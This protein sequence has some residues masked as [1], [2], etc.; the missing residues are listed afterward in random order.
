MTTRRRMLQWSGAALATAALPGVTWA[1]NWPDKPIRAIVP[2]T[3]GSTTDI[4]GR[5]VLSELSGALGQS[6]V[7]ENRAGA[8]GTIGTDLVAKSEPDGYTVLVHASAHSAAPAAYPRAPYNAARDLAGV[9]IF[10][11][12]PNVTVISPAKGIKTLSELVE[13]AK[14]RNVTFASAGVGSATHWAAERLILSAGIKATHVPYKGGPEALT[15]VMTGR[16]DFMCTGVSSGLNFIRSGKLLPLAVS[17]T[18]R[19]SA[20]PEVPTTIEAGFPNSDY[21]FWNG[22]LVPAKTPRPI[23]DRLYHETVKVLTHPAVKEK[24]KP[25][26]VETM[27]L[28]PT[29]FDALIAKEIKNN[30][31]IVKAAGLKFN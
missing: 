31:A 12:V 16:V 20:L 22:L 2:F 23:V 10:G 17:T 4:I 11:V 28:K 18:K 15:D 6:I 7:V 13:T 25:Q 5:I 3:P 27:P 19:S 14:K 29:E 26:A 30:L 24:F 21:T 9:T 1:R 8:G